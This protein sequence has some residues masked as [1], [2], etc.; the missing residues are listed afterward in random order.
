MIVIT[1][2]ICLAIA[3]LLS[4]IGGDSWINLIYS[5]IIG[6]LSSLFIN[7]GRW[8]VSAWLLYRKKQ[9]TAELINGW[10]GWRWVI[11]LVVVGSLLGYAL[12]SWLAAELTDHVGDMP[13]GQSWQGW[14]A[15]L[16]ISTGASLGVTW[17]FFTRASMAASQA[18]AE[19]AARTAAQMQ[20]RLLQSQLEPHML[21]NTLANLRALIG[22]D[23]ERAQQMLDQLID[24]LRATLSASQASLHPLQT[25]FDRVADY[26]ALMQVRMGSRLSVT[27]D[28]PPE[29]AT[30][31]VPPLLLQP[32]VENAIKHG[33]EP[34]RRGGHI[35]LSAQ[36]VN[37]QLH[38]CVEDTGQGLGQ[39]SGFGTTLV[40]E[41]LQTLYG[42]QASFDLKRVNGPEGHRHEARTRATVTLPASHP[43]TP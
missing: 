39:G 28:L 5:L 12:G 29:L 16:L 4:L 42:A 6:N 24:F 43:M 34:Q 21:F 36:I 20:L 30:Q 11:P 27:L 17:L 7:G 22:V 40:R 19:A 32:L 25:E 9:H 23:A 10:P 13:T 41:R 38:L 8:G 37:D 3:L 31:P 15:I 18:A 1:E 2:L 35:R 33:L 14:L 26:L